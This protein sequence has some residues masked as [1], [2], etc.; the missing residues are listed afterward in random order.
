[1]EY[2][3]G[4]GPREQRE[5]PLPEEREWEVGRQ[6]Q[7]G[8]RHK[9]TKSRG[10]LLHETQEKANWWRERSE[11]GSPRGEGLNS[12]QK[13]APGCLWGAENVFCLDLGGGFTVAHA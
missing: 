2:G 10:S 11:S 5:A 1:M 13:G 7:K 9:V 8:G 4:A 12:H 6:T 3:R